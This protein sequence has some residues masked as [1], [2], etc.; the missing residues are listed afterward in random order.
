MTLTVCLLYCHA[1]AEL[2]MR[3]SDWL[4]TGWEA[5]CCSGIRE[6]QMHGAA[7]RRCAGIKTDGDKLSENVHLKK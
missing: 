2:F 4:L 7:A 1:A 6:Q 3:L 5:P